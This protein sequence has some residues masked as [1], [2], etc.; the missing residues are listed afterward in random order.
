[1]LDAVIA[2]FLRLSPPSGG[3]DKPIGHEAEPEIHHHSE[4]EVKRM[5]LSSRRQGGLKCE[6]DNI[7]QNNRQQRLKEID[8]HRW[9]RHRTTSGGLLLFP[10]HKGLLLLTFRGK[11][12]ACLSFP[13]R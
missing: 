6:V 13:R 8:D 2:R 11:F 12:S 4:V 3:T 7:S 10:A 9:F 5:M 1:P